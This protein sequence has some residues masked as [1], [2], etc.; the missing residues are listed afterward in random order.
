MHQPDYRNYQDDSYMLPWTYLHAI[1]DYADMAWHLEQHP[2]LRCVVNFAP[3]LLDQLEDYVLQVD[4]GSIRDPLLSLLAEPDE[5]LVSS[6]SAQRVLQFC[7]RNNH[8]HM[9]E[10]FSAYRRLYD[11]FRMVESDPDALAYLGP[12][13]YADL[14]TWYHLSWTGESLRRTIPLIARLMGK[15]AGFTFTDRN[16]LLECIKDVLRGLIGRYRKL[17]QNGQIEL[18][19]NPQQH[20]ILPLLIDFKAAHENA[21]DMLLPQSE[22]Y[23]GGSDRAEWHVSEALEQHARRFGEKPKGLWPAEGAVSMDTLHFFEKKG[24][25]WTASSEAVLAA[26]II[27]AGGAV[28]HKEAW[29]YKPYRFSTPEKKI[30]CFFRDERLSDL[31]G[32]EYAQWL[33][34]DAVHHFVHELEQIADRV[35]DGAVVSVILDGENA[36]ESYP[37]NGYYFLEQLYDALESHERISLSVFSECLEGAAELDHLVAGSWV[38]GTFSTWMG[39]KEKN[40]AWD[41]L[42]EAKATVDEVL[43]L[44][45][46]GAEQL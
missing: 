32:F 1:K 33:A 24:I 10:P 20:P 36:W 42:C 17:A 31:I 4:T 23:P 26:S 28:D 22:G 7:F 39:S 45:H 25:V 2:G 44:E 19:A 35:D 41:I 46:L 9:L 34:R 30:A 6:E 8:A 14:I 3:V 37:Y 21:P 5:A 16:N 43:A 11:I 15:G 13:F 18:S 27:K 38:Y 40:L 12:C 29:L